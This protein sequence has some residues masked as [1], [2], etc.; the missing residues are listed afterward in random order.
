MYHI[1]DYNSP[2]GKMMLESDEKYLTGIWFYGGKYFGESNAKERTERCTPV[3]A[4]AVSWLNRYFKG[5]NPPPFSEFRM[6][7]SDFQVAVWKILLSI[8]YGETVSYRDIALRL[9][10]E[11]GARMSCQAV[12]NAVGHNKISII[13]PCHRVIGTDGSLRGYA[14]GIDRKTALL[15]LEKG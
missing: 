2:L 12:G 1:Y 6:T 3:I 14:G 7:G 13:I 11:R 8:P 10:R 5:E 4:E 15:N 9:E